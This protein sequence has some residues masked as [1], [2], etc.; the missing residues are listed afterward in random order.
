MSS[1]FFTLGNDGSQ[2]TFI[3]LICFPR[4]TLLQQL[5]DAEE[6]LQTGGLAFF[7]L[8]SSVLISFTIFATTF[9][10]ANESITNFHILEVACSPLTCEGTHIIFSHVLSWN[11]HAQSLQ[12]SLHMTQ[13]QSGWGNDHI[14]L[15]LIKALFLPS[16]YQC[17]GICQFARIALPVATDDGFTRHGPNRRVLFSRN[18]WAKRSVL[19]RN[20]IFQTA[21]K[22]FQSP[23]ISPFKW[24]KVPLMYLNCFSSRSFKSERCLITS[25]EK[26]MCSEW[27]RH[28][29]KI[30]CWWSFNSITMMEP[31]ASWG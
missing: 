22:W 16:S 19:S 4:L 6:H 27:G 20:L 8:D 25:I 9:W 29:Q 1:Q 3:H 2:L 7:H 18:C 17:L 21:R 5:T 11:L 26:I 28:L 31:M 23:K 24:C 12:R 15:V 14:H 10:V 13:V 30:Q